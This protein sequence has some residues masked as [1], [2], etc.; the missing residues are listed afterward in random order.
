MANTDVYWR[1]ACLR[2][3][4]RTVCE[5]PKWVSSDCGREHIGLWCNQPTNPLTC[6]L[7]PDCGHRCWLWHVNKCYT[8]VLVLGYQG[9]IGEMQ[10]YYSNKALRSHWKSV[11]G[12]S[13]LICLIS[14]YYSFCFRW[15]IFKPFSLLIFFL[16]LPVP[17]S[18]LAPFSPSSCWFVAAVLA[19]FY[20]SGGRD[21]SVVRALDSWLKGHGFDSPGSTFCADSYFRI[22]STSVLP[23]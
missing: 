5:C 7:S 8:Q 9:A 21:S 18:S 20:T 15:P 1:F 16:G 6:D 14:I 19:L 17:S 23:Q 13:A 11:Y 12:L 10:K 3:T 4:E 22:S 2:K